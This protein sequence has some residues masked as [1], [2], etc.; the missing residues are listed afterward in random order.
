VEAFFYPAHVITSSEGGGL[1]NDLWGGERKKERRQAGPTTAGQGREIQKTFGAKGYKK[2]LA[3]WVA[4]SF[5][6][7]K[8]LGD[9]WKKRKIVGA[10]R[11]SGT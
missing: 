5:Y 8:E 3:A 10:G 9:A 7:A 11:D 1:E 4:A 2:K 6:E